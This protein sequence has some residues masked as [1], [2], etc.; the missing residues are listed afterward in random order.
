MVREGR[1]TRGCGCCGFEEEVWRDEARVRGRSA[2][3]AR[4]TVCLVRC[5][6]GKKD[7]IDEA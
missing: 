1:R 5:I 3:C 6:G 2:E 7:V 4:K